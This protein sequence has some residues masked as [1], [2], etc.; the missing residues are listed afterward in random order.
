MSDTD[1]L[2]EKAPSRRRRWLRWIGLGAL[3]AF[4]LVV[5]A[6]VVAYV[7]TDVPAPDQLAVAGVTRILYS[8]GS[9][10]GRMGTQNRIPVRLDQVPLPVQQEVLAAEDRGFYT[11]P[12]ISL[13]GI[14]RALLTNLRGGGDIQQGGSTITQQYAKNAYLSSERTYTRKIKEILIAVKMTRQESKDQI[15]Q[16]YLNTIYFGRGAYGIQVASQSYFGKPVDQLTPAE[17]AVLAASIRSPAGYD[18]EKHP[19]AAKARWRYVLDGMVSKGWLS[20][21]EADGLTYP[22]VLPAAQAGKA[23]DLSGPK[24]HVLTRVMDEVETELQKRGQTNLIAKGLDVTTTLSRPAQEAAVAAVQKVV[25][26]PSEGDP[27][28]P[29]GALVSLDPRNGNVV[30]Y[31]GGATGTGFDYA[32]Q[33]NGRQPGSSFKP[34]TLASALDQGIGLRSTFDGSTPQY[35]PGLA[36]PVTNFN[37]ENFGR[38]DLVT[39]TEHSINTV[40]FAL[41][42]KAGPKKIADLAHAA[43]ISTDLGGTDPAAGI[44]LGIYDVRVQDQAVGYAAFANGGQRVTPHFV[45]SVAQAGKELYRTS[46]QLTRA[47]PDPVAADATTAMQAVIKSGTGTQAQLAGGRPAAGKTGTTENN[48]DVW[49]CGYTPQLATAVWVGTGQNLKLPFAGGQATGGTVT[50]GIWKQYTDAALAGQPVLQFPPPANI[51]RAVNPVPTG[52][53][54]TQSSATPSPTPSPTP[55]P[56]P[57]TPP[58][59]PVPTTPPP[60]TIPPVRPPSVPASGSPGPTSPPASPVAGKSPGAG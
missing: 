57:T 12:G 3:G 30:A 51:G 7:R 16:N 43:G 56:A 26:T 24:G 41:A 20:R 40:Y 42:L 49:F 36:K 10:I 25:G 14:A 44:A 17:G 45:T 59:A 48:F 28:A 29:K 8:D 46:P 54:P 19:D 58:P 22:T 11:E 60:T 1:V 52:P 23:N 34:Y 31:Y 9:E 38:V 32:S 5:L 15:L 35:F 47:F 18:P 21:A 6:V 27:K 2:P 55:T 37:N 13:T 33:G 4:V 53:A 50:A 39:A